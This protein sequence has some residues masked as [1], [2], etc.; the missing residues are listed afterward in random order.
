MVLILGPMVYSLIC[1]IFSAAFFAMGGVFTLFSAVFLYLSGMRGGIIGTLISSIPTCLIIFM[2]P[3]NTG[4]ALGYSLFLLMP[5]LVWIALVRFRTLEQLMMDMSG[6]SEKRIDGFGFPNMVYLYIYILMFVYA[7]ALCFPAVQ[8]LCAQSYRYLII[9][10]I[11]FLH[12]QSVVPTLGDVMTSDLPVMSAQKLLSLEDKEKLRDVL[13]M[14]PGN[15]AILLIGIHWVCWKISM[16]MSSYFKQESQ[17]KPHPLDHTYPMWGDVVFM[18]CLAVQYGTYYVG[19][20]PLS[21]FMSAIFASLSSLPL[22]FLGLRILYL[23]SKRRGI[24][25]KMFKIIV[26]VSFLLGFPFV[27][28]ILLGFIESIF[29]ISKRFGLSHR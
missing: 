11:K 15:F 9:L 7:I 26:G 3:Q 5:T 18:V 29:N 23:W 22:L 17:W 8:T 25:D 21:Q 6:A 28:V 14:L 10:L 1:G 2:I 24:K 12:P 20:S 19:A 4:M 27:I 13:Q 16:K